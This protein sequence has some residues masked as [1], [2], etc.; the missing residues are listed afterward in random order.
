MSWK[1]LFPQKNFRLKSMSLI[2]YFL[3]AVFTTLVAY[4]WWRE[5]TVKS[6]LSPADDDDKPFE[7]DVPKGPIS[8]PLVGNLIQ[9]GDRAHE[10]MMKWAKTYGPIYQ[11]YLG[12]Q[13]VVVLNGTEIIREALIG[14][15]EVFASRPQLYMIH[16]FLKGS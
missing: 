16:A 8:F 15:S 1:K 3:L 14:Q 13:R 10:T 5:W 2:T 4:L 12:S 6:D 7:L 9:L 11:V